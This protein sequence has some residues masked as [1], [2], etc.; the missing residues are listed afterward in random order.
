M[1]LPYTYLGVQGTEIGPPE[2]AGGRMAVGAF[3]LT[4]SAAS[5]GAT[6]ELSFD[7]NQTIPGLTSV[8]VMM[9]DTALGDQISVDEP[10]FSVRRTVPD[11]PSATYEVT[12]VSGDQV[13]A[14]ADFTVLEMRGSDSNSN[15]VVLL[16]VLAVVAGLGW[17]ATRLFHGSSGAL[18]PVDTWYAWREKRRR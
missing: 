15:P 2:L 13:L 5:P 18:G 16:G 3:S 10:S 7:F 14:A 9:G 12:V 11:L 1:T 17:R 6:L 8:E 4:P